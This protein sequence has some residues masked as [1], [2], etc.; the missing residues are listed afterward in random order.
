VPKATLNERRKSPRQWKGKKCVRKIEGELTVVRVNTS[1][2]EGRR[3]NSEKESSPAIEDDSRR[4]DDRLRPEK[5]KSLRRRGGSSKELRLIRRPAIP[6]GEENGSARREN[7]IKG[8][9][10][11]TDAKHVVVNTI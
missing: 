6:A 10:G 7:C 5:L 9:E 2:K 1:V 4:G 8:R 11:T 3:G